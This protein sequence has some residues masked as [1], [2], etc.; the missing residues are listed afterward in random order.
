M[1]LLEEL[2]VTFEMMHILHKQNTRIPNTDEII[3]I[4]IN[5]I[6]RLGFPISLVHI[7][8]NTVSSK[9]TVSHEN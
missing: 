3:H 4:L 8:Y 7:M 6:Q 5:M 1:L 2:H 9:K